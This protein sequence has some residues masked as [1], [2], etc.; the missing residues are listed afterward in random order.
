MDTPFHTSLGSRVIPAL[1]VS[2]LACS[3]PALLGQTLESLLQKRSATDAA[4]ESQDNAYKPN[5]I[6]ILADDLGCG[7]VACNNPESLIPTQ[8]SDLLASQGRRIPIAHTPASVCSPPRSSLST[9]RY[10]WRSPMKEGVLHDYD[11]ALIK[12]GRTTTASL[13]HDVDY[14]TAGFGNWRI[15]LDRTPK[16][17][18]PGDWQ[19]GQIFRDAPLRSEE[20]VDL[21][22]PVRNGPT[23]MGFETLF[24]GVQQ[25]I[26]SHYTQDDRV[27][28]ETVDRAE[29][30]NAFSGEAEAFIRKHHAEKKEKPSFVYLGLAAVHNPYFPP[31]NLQRKSKMGKL[32][33]LILWIDQTVGRVTALLDELKIADDTLD[34][35][36]S[37]NGSI[38]YPDNAKLGHNTDGEWRGYK[39]DIWHGGTHVPF[40]ARGPKRINAQC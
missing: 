36:T 17:G 20:R 11:P 21:T 33:D 40:I 13:L 10:P 14:H 9:E 16:A 7:D 34:I 2:G 8:Y 37:D 6:V 30:D 32:G 31:A 1:P 25:G 3:S 15:S 35:L 29:I 19:W 24:G 28:Q 22:K 4:P 12:K 26:S 18:D 38:A 39:T 5:I 27:S 23:D